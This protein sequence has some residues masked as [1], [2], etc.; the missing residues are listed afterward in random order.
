MYRNSGGG[1]MMMF[2]PGLLSPGSGQVSD[3]GTGSEQ[4]FEN[5]VRA[6]DGCVVLYDGKQGDGDY[7][8]KCL[9]DQTSAKIT[10]LGSVGMHDKASAIDVGKG[11][12]A[13]LYPHN[14]F[15]GGSSLFDKPGFFVLEDEYPGIEGNHKGISSLRIVKQ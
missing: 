12:K 9:D 3:G 7:T 13:Y 5:I 8:V 1:A 6:E 14:D 4:I 2:L 11:V 10:D 15:K